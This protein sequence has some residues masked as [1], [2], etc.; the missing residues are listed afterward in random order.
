MYCE[1]SPFITKLQ[2]KK[3]LNSHKFQIF[4]NEES[5]LIITGVGKIKAAIAVTY[6]FSKFPPKDSDLLLNIGVCGTKEKA[7]DIGTVF[8]CNK[9]VENDTKRTFYPDML[10]NHPFEETSIE[11]VSSALNHD[12]I[13][14]EGQLVDM[15]A[16]GV[17]QSASIFMQ[18]HQVSFVKIVSDYLNIE[19]ISQSQISKLIGDRTPEI[20]AWIHEVKSRF[21]LNSHILSLTEQG[22]LNQ[23]ASRLK[24][25]T[26]MKNQ[27]RQLLIYYKLQY[28]DFTDLISKYLN[29]ECNSKDEGKKYFAEIKSKII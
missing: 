15:E 26:T 29:V 22:L 24:L 27:F 13:K 3:D 2:L 28:G 8:F 5:I 23:M 11:T 10:F 20:I 12:G 18:A 6:L 4:K 19:N 16:S 14:L 17:Y 1:A 9:I 21:I 7:V 25:S